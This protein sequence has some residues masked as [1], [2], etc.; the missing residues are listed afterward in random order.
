MKMGLESTA[1]SKLETHTTAAKIDPNSEGA[2]FA[3]ELAD[4]TATSNVNFR[5]YD[6][7]SKL[8]TMSASDRS[9]ALAAMDAELTRKGLLPS[10][11]QIFSEQ[12]DNHN[13]LKADRRGVHADTLNY[14]LNPYDPRYAD[15]LKGGH[16]DPNQNPV[17][18][19]LTREMAQ[20]VAVITPPGD[21]EVTYGRMNKYVADQSKQYADVITTTAMMNEYGT[22]KG[23][24]DLSN[25]MPRI[26]ADSI[27]NAIDFA[28]P[29]TDTKTLAWMKDHYRQLSDHG[30]GITPGS[31]RRFAAGEGVF[32][33]PP[34]DKPAETPSA[35]DA[36][37][38]T[39]ANIKPA[40]IRPVQ[41]SDKKV[42]PLDGAHQDHTS[43]AMKA[44]TDAAAKQI[45]VKA[46]ESMKD[47]AIAELKAEGRL[48]ANA[49]ANEL[50]HANKQI[51]YEEHL[52]R[53][54]TRTVFKN[55]PN[56]EGK[57]QAGTVLNVAPQQP[58]DN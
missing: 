48:S 34:A 51:A 13:I 10:A 45:T 2:K 44:H 35:A 26:T 1:S 25:G 33:A 12:T 56:Y 37:P 40:D 42:T 57:L 47:V 58:K 15:K 7:D 22:R 29:T 30:G 43:G 6:I 41:A 11:M 9:Q 16:W 4:G 46:G 52:I 14:N 5:I 19:L 50:A 36:T 27:Q 21:D 32:P 31:M 17:E 39:A 38:L 3:H 18:M 24:Y 20:N 49:S 8:N 53:L 55:L 23:F 28:S 54:Y